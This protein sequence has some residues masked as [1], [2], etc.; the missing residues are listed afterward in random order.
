VAGDLRLLA[1]AASA[2][3]VTLSYTGENGE[4][5]ALS[6]VLRQ[7]RLVSAAAFVRGDGSVAVADPASA[8]HEFE[9][10]GVIA[11]ARDAIAAQ[12]PLVTDLIDANGLMRIYCFVPFR[13]TEVRPGGA[14][15][16]SIDAADRRVAGILAQEALDESVGLELRD[17]A[18]RII[19]VRVGPGPDGAGDGSAAVAPVERTPWSLSLLEAQASTEGPIAAFRLRSLWLAPTLAAFAMLL[20]WGIASSVRRPLAGLTAAAERIAR[21]DLEQP[22]EPPGSAGGGDEIARLT[23]ALDQMRTSLKG[24]ID[25]IA[26]ANR[27]LEQRVADRTRELASLNARLEERERLRQQLLRK[28]I[29]AQEEE[30]KRIARELHDETSQTLAALAMGVESALAASGSGATAARVKELRELVDRM[31]REL[32]RLI[33][34][35]RPSVLDDLGLAA[36][37]RWFAD[38]HLGAEGIAV[39]CELDD[40]DVR[41]PPASETALFRAVQE[42]IVNIARHS[43][44]ESVLI[45][46]DVDRGTLTIEVEDDG[47]G[48]QP[49]LISSDPATLRGV[50]LLGMRERM[51]ILGG[52]ID[53]ES[54]PGAGTRVVL[55]VPVVERS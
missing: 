29:S 34:D 32:H 18:G 21:G 14:V 40:L 47:R 42:A 19:G 4:R 28:V 51:E 11:A 12:R 23:G 13:T 30:R 46:G 27:E 38:R 39:R 17:G 22:V 48:F 3:H 49:D 15:A 25:E 33:V 43:G 9:A 52:T 35:L 5:E 16:A 7:A 41:L 26:R 54:E 10:P 44:A 36:A 31:H 50:G 8:Y 55:K 2:P 1:G 24:S 45:Q 20:G 53:V 6:A 37:I